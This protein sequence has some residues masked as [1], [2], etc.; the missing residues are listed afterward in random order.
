MEE[1]RPKAFIHALLVSIVL[2]T[3]LTGVGNVVLAPEDDPRLGG[4]IGISACGISFLVALWLATGGN[5]GSQS[6]PF[7][8]NVRTLFIVVTAMAIIFWFGRE[9]WQSQDRRAL[10]R[11]FESKG[12]ETRTERVKGYW[13]V[14]TLVVPSGQL[15]NDELSKLRAAF[16]DAVLETRSPPVY[17]RTP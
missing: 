4:V 7:Q 11:D 1:S 14:K 3:L 2:A 12:G 9:V 15:T 6:R 8:F 17:S 5:Q 16:P 13:V 10:R